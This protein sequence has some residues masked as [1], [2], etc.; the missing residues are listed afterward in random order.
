[1][2]RFAALIVLIL[3]AGCSDP[4][5]NEAPEAPTSTQGSTGTN[6]NATAQDPVL[7]SVPVAFDG[8][9]GSSAHSCVFPAGQCVTQVVVAPDANVFVE[10]PGANFTGLDLNLTWTATSPATQTLALRFMVMAD[11]EGCSTLYEEVTGTSPLRATLSGENVPLNATTRVHLFVYNP[12]GLQVVPGG[13][14]Y[15]F[16]SVDESFRL[17]GDVRLLVPA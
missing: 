12:A 11:C 1:M 5:S 8:N 17:E 16:T 13:A 14:G 6:D 4:P 10:H 9:L 7:L 15:T 2:H 3:L